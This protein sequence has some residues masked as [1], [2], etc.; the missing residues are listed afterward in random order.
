ML[1]CP[2]G[3]ALHKCDP[4][5]YPY[6][7]K[8]VINYQVVKRL[9]N[10]WISGNTRENSSKYYVAKN[11][12]FFYCSQTATMI[13]VQEPDVQCHQHRTGTLCSQC[14]PGYSLVLGSSKCTNC[15]NA[16]LAFIALIIFNGLRLFLF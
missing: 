2:L 13:N 6:T 12:P 16:H 4:I 7:E 1:P 11:C 5:L 3:F 10:C 9:A 8:C 14:K 15:T